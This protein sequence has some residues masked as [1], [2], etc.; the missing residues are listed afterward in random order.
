M[1][2]S[3]EWWS[4]FIRGGEMEKMGEMLEMPLRKMPK[5][6][7]VLIPAALKEMDL[8]AAQQGVLRLG[9]DAALGEEGDIGC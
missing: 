8:A 3:L 7:I 5:D 1:R 4:S 9:N 2:H 6:K